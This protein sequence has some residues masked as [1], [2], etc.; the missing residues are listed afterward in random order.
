M[1][2]G[3]K[4]AAAFLAEH[5][6]YLIYTHA[7]PDAD[8]IGSGAAL[9]SILRSC[10][11]KAFAV[12]PEVIPAKLSFIPV[13]GIFIPLPEDIS[14]FTA[15]S[16]DVAGP[17]MLTGISIPRFE[18]SID[19]HRIN[20]I[21]CSLLC[22][23]R[24]FAATGEIICS[25][26]RELGV[27]LTKELALP[28]YAAICSDSGGFR[29]DATRPETLITAAELIAT[30]IDFAYICRRLFECKTI[31][32]IEL[33]KIAYE[34]LVICRN[35]KFAYISITPEE[36]MR[37]GA[38]DSDFESLNAIPRQI[39]NVLAS[40]MIREKNGVIKVSMRS[41]AAI[42]V[43]AIA[44]SH[45]GGGHYHAAGFSMHGSISD[46]ISEIERIFAEL[47]K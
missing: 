24:S 7:S 22:D 3:I 45:G 21:D 29:Y 28:L 20:S 23:M 25:I 31:G 32:Q 10:G 47:D 12:C 43:S 34:K 26:A 46:A 36:F 2:I 13:D 38:T 16:V 35:G 8:T 18:L 33:E 15:I 9:V 5:D 39:E 11:K 1:E 40:A 37:S 6:N 44:L 17:K 19:H 14:G 4:E 42:D 30:G 27:R 41:N